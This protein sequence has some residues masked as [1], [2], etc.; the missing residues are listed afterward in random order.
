MGQESPRRGVEPSQRLEAVK[1]RY[2]K[3]GEKYREKSMPDPVYVV[4]ID[5]VRKEVHF[6]SQPK[7]ESHL[8]CYLADL[9]EFFDREGNE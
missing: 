8:T 6:S 7:G 3:I 4:S 1:L 9:E 5:R 2:P